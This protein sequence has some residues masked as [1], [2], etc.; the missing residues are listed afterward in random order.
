M[1]ND[2]LLIGKTITNVLYDSS[3]DE[4]KIILYF[5][6]GTSAVITSTASN[7]MYYLFIEKNESMKE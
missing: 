5:S 3:G 2:N 4:D 6:D 7:F 1:D